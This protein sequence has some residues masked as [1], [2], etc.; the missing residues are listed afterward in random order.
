MDNLTP[1][2]RSENMRRIKSKDTKPERQVRS[3]LSSC[4]YRYRLH[5]ADLPG[6]PDIVF[7]KKAKAIFVHGCFWHMHGRCTAGRFPRSRLDYWVPKLLRNKKRDT[8]ARARLRRMGWSVLVVWECELDR[9]NLLTK[10]LRD[11]L[12]ADS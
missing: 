8:T 12:S 1:E 7:P 2:R 10:R 9:P 3:L 6:C 11:F 5:R 4:G